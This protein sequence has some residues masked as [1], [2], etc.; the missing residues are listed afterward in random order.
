MIFSELAFACVLYISTYHHTPAKCDS[1]LIAEIAAGAEGSSAEFGVPVD[2]IAAV[3]YHE[4]KFKPFS[5]GRRGE[6]GLM[7]I[8]RRGA[9][10][11]PYLRMSFRQL[12]DVR[13][14]IRIGTAYLARALIRCTGTRGLTI[15]NGGR[16]GSGSYRTGV[17]TDLRLGRSWIP[18]VAG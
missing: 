8:K 13:L 14:N 1:P 11:G 5:R 12:A 7:Q 2:I 3:I 6:I 10:Q 16:C 17:L 4:S 18:R 9:I 15:Y